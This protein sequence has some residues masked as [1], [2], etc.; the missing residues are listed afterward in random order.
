MQAIECENCKSGLD[1]IE[2]PP[3]IFRKCKH[4]ICEKCKVNLT[5]DLQI[6]DE[7][8]NMPCPLKDC[9]LK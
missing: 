9:M 1:I 3:F 4:T 8:I 5:K 6:D 7:F 2:N